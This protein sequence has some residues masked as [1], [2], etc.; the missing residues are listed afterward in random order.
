M[1]E[2][3][4]AAR[5]RIEQDGY[6]GGNRGPIPE[7]DGATPMSTA[8]ATRPT[9]SS[10]APVDSPPLR[11]IT[12]DEYEKII[13]S[14]ALEDP[15]RVEL[16]DGSMVNKMGKKAEHSYATMQT[17]KALAA[18]LPDGWSSRQEQPV[19]IPDYDEP[20]P[21]V[22]IVRGSDAD[23]EHRIPTAA[24][25][26]LLVEVSDTT[27]KLDRSK[28]LP[29]YARSKIPVYWIVNL[30]DR[31]VE[32]HSRPGKNGYRSR[33]IFASGEQVPLTIGGQ[34]LLP[35]PVDSLLPR[36][37]PTKGKGRPKGNGA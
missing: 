27:L 36:L 20:E 21:D 31:Q 32:V 2:G 12:V 17:T 33:R 35:I 4:L 14:G 16:I 23:Y 19:R 18:R 26:A 5:S 3:R 25:V 29:I 15:G 13:A 37:K 1:A 24:D 11:R 30:V 34:E 10:P 22:S 6:Q 9:A 7:T 8:T 28:R